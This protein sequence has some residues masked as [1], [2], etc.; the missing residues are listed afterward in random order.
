ML[1][2]LTAITIIAFDQV[3][4]YLIRAYMHEGQAIPSEGFAWLIR[5]HNSRGQLGWIVI[6]TSIIIVAI[7][8]SYY[9]FVSRKRLPSIGLGLILGGLA[10]NLIDRLWLGYV[11]DFI[12]EGYWVFNIAD[13][14]FLIGI[15]LTTLYVFWWEWMLLRD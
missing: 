2:Y 8:F 1:F 5:F 4:K 9:Y 12:H 6:A 3:S 10:G 14:A 13:V 15:A 7:I 11:T